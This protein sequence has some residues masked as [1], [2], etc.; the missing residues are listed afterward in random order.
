VKWWPFGGEGKPPPP[1]PARPRLVIEL[2]GRHADMTCSWPPP[3]TASEALD[4]ANVFA[5]ML[6]L[7]QSGQLAP[8][9]QR[10]L[11][12]ASNNDGEFR[13]AEQIL[14][15]LVRMDRQRRAEEPAIRPQDFFPTEWK[16]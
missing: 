4:L 11:G 9:V 14:L 12:A 6:N 16:P 2:T 15:N 5:A 8:S 3:A 7:L 1:P 10:A 13:V